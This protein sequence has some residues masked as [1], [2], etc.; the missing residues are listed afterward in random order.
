MGTLASR[1]LGMV[2]EVLIAATFP[3]EV[4]D[5]FFVAWRVPNALRAL[6]AE[7]AASAAL[8]P[9]FSQALASP[10]EDGS[11]NIARLRE[12]MAR[13]GGA[14]LVVLA[15]ATGL[16]IAFARPLFAMVSGG[17]NGDAARFELGV[18]LLRVLFP[19]LFLMGWFSLGRTALERLGD[20]STG[21]KASVL[22]NVAF[23]LAPF[24]MVPFAPWLGVAPIVM[25][26]WAAVLGGLL[27]VLYLRPALRRKGVLVRPSLARDEAHSD[28]AKTFATMLVGQLVYQATVML[29]A[30]LLA[31]LEPGSASWNSYAQ[32]LADIPQGLFTVSLAG[33]AAAEMEKFAVADD[34]ASVARTFER[35]LS[36]SAF[37]ALPACVL[38]AVY[39]DAI[40]PLVFGY[41][42]FSRGD[43]GA[44]NA[45]E[46]ARSLEWQS[47]GVALFAF[48]HPTTRVFAA[49]KRRRPILASSALAL[50]AFS[51]AGVLLAKSRGHVGVAMA[52]ALS[53]V[54][55]LTALLVQVARE[56]P[57]APRN[58]LP[59]LAKVLAAT[60][61]C[62]LAARAAV[63]FLPITGF[64]WGDKALAVVVGAGLIVVYA[65]AAWV[66]RCEEMQEIADRIRRRRNRAP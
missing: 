65:S 41:G 57:F 60:G 43:A 7:G 33:A 15:L 38:L 14:A 44:R 31:T 61:V 25:M 50:F 17:F 48:V 20:F 34:R 6:L 3:K 53:A 35:T 19:F 32:R 4:T 27:Q 55:Q 54:V 49:F 40:V 47:L 8:G 13:V 10:T 42:R 26:A 28:V 62:A 11:K 29:S 23:V 5:V 52:G 30:R 21:S 66:F 63:K 45:F 22:Q 1:V 51:I 18:V 16:G 12:V 24:A 56:I 58:V 36:L 9:A 2:R 46:V 59:S 37:V 64:S 39:S